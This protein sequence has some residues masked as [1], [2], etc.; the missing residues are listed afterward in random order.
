MSIRVLVVDDDQDILLMLSMTLRELGLD[1]VTAPDAET[2][3]AIYHGYL[4]DVILLDVVMPRID[5]FELLE[6]WREE[7]IRTP[8][9][10]HT[11]YD[12]EEL[13]AR[14]VASG[15][16]ELVIKPVSAEV[17]AG[18]LKTAAGEGELVSS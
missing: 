2:A 6:E 5:G 14:A 4:P 18:M 16:C 13:R 17:L 10:L 9:L 15:A 7:G 8:V 1:V 12:T 3:H 11:A